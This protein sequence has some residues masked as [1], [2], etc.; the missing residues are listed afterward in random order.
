MG[1]DGS[2]LSYL[3]ED[4][5]FIGTTVSWGSGSETCDNSTG[6][7]HG[8]LVYSPKKSSQS[9]EFKVIYTKRNQGPVSTA[10]VIYQ[11]LK[12]E[13]FGPVSRALGT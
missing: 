2:G 9:Q 13:V 1:M 11:V 7:L 12:Q 8:E 4:L 6:V 10:R 3:S 5:Y